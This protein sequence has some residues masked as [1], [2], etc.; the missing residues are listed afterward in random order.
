V[1]AA[2]TALQEAGQDIVAKAISDAPADV[3]AKIRVSRGGPP[4]PGGPFPPR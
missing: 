1:R 4:G 2:T 3:R